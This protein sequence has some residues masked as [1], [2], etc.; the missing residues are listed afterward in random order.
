MVVHGLALAAD[1]LGEPMA[2]VTSEAVS[3]AVDMQAASVAGAT[4]VAAVVTV[5]AVT[6]K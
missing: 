6:G 3:L 5:V 4:R 1:V 2:A